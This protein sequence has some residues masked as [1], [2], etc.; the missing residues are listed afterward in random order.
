MTRLEIVQIPVLRDNY[1][2]LIH[3]PTTGAVAAIDPAVAEP[4]LDAL[5]ARGW[6]LTHILSTHHHWDHVGANLDLKAATGCTIV[7]ARVDAERIPGIDVQVSDG[8]TYS[9]GSARAQVFFVPGHTSGHIAYYFP[10][11]DAL[12]CGDTVF[13]IGCGRLFEGTPEQMWRSISRLRALPD[14]TRIYCGHEY[15]ESNVRFALSIEPDHQPL[16]QYAA[17]V[18]RQRAQNLPTIPSTIGLEKSAS[19]FFRA[20]TARL[21][22]AV[23]MPGADPAAVFGEVRRRKD[24]F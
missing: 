18:A 13:S 19:P 3:D 16:V 11:S 21:Q 24:N 5:A 1:L 8:E 17:H 6:T 4:A 22:R 9:L 2:Y 23:K 10:D 7:G 20:D 12:F 15:T 14:E